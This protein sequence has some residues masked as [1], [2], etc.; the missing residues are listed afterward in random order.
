VKPVTVDVFAD[1]TCPWCHVGW[2]ALKQAAAARQ[3]EI[4]AN[5][6]WRGFMLAPDT[7]REGVDRRAYLTQR[8]QPEQL[9]AAHDA[10]N[11]A[12]EAA[13]VALQLD[14]PA[15]IPNTIDA[16]RLIHWASEQG[17]AERVID[18][19]FA[20][21]WIDG[22]D[23]GQHSELVAIAESIGMDPHETAAKLA[24]EQDRAHVLEVHEAGKSIGVT[25]VPVIIF[26]RRVPV[27]G[28]QSA[29]IYSRAIDAALQ[30][31][32]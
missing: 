8:F 13:N 21:Y 22:R 10:L 19:L 26:N 25:G 9:R 31:V 6:S 30:S 15:R 7:P 2:A 24:T 12:A 29:E 3:G 32:S 14:A 16:H 17:I 28:A 11:A 20:A 18:A 23:I 4:A 1:I 27:L 5:V